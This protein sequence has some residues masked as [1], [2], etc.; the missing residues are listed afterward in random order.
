MEEVLAEAASTVVALEASVV[1]SAEEDFAD[2]G[3]EYT[4]L[5]SITADTIL[6]H[7]DTLLT[8]TTTTTTMPAVTWS[9]AA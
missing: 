9:V 7:T 2:V 8:R 3:L 1:G 4:A 5:G 6:T